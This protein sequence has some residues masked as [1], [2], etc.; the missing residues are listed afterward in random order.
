MATSSKIKLLLY[1]LLGMHGLR[2]NNMLE[3]KIW[4]SKT[5]LSNERRFFTLIAQMIKI[6]EHLE[7]SISYIMMEWCKKN[8]K[9]LLK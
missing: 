7:I 4:L 6:S 8:K 1:F 5:L 3:K 9:A 2:K